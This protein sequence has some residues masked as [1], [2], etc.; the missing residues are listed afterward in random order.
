MTNR[1]TYTLLVGLVVAVYGLIG[2]TIS[3]EIQDVSRPEDLPPLENMN[4]SS[5]KT[6]QSGDTDGSNTK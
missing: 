6:E 2:C 5:Q 3:H 4:D 1:V